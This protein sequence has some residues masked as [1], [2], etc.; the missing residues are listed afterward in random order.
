MSP[1]PAGPGP[2]GKRS[3][4]PKLLYGEVPA[5]KVA[6]PMDGPGALRA[7]GDHKG[8]GLA[9]VTELLAGALT[10]AG[11]AG[12]LPRPYANNMLAIFLDVAAFD[13]GGGFAAEI[14][15]YIDFFTS[16]RPE[17]EDGQV[18][19]PGEPERLART[20][21]LANGVP[22]A[23]GAWRDI[24]LTASKVGLDQ[25]RIDALIGDGLIG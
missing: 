22:M 8:S 20:E 24:L 17:K 18:L 21:R 12:P 3:N 23:G 7:L 1:T 16:S 10:G 19:I 9:F 15:S 11:C 14:K 4:D 2:D 13:D 6:N 25:A 5:G